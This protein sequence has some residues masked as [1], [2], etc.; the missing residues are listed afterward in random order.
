MRLLRILLVMV[1]LAGASQAQAV[2]QNGTITFGSTPPSPLVLAVPFGTFPDSGLSFY[3]TWYLD[4]DA[5]DN[6]IPAASGLFATTECSSTCYGTTLNP[7]RIGVVAAYDHFDITTLDLASPGTS[8]TIV[9]EAY[10]D[11]AFVNSKVIPV[12]SGYK[13]NTVT[14]NFTNISELRFIANSGD[15]WINVD[16]LVVT[17]NLPT[18]T[19]TP[20]AGALTGGASGSPTARPSSAAAARLIPTP[21][22]PEP[23]PRA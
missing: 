11:G 15:G 21:S 3:N 16:N 17:P 13:F 9:I 4:V 8:T 23:C 5:G 22:P 6:Y 14:L 20:A 7:A 12:T 1:C 19:M 10:R 2:V 18:L